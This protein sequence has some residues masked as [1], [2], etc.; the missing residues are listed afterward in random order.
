MAMV[1]MAPMVESPSPSGS[2]R[3]HSF[4]STTSALWTGPFTFHQ[5]DWLEPIFDSPS[6]R[7]VFRTG[8]Q[9]SKSTSQAATMLE[10]AATH[11]SFRTLYVTPTTQQMREFSN[12]RLAPMIKDSPIFRAVYWNTECQDQVSNRSLRNRSHITLGSAYHSADSLRGISSH[13]LCLDEVQD[14]LME[15]IKVL[16][17]TTFA[18]RSTMG[19]DPYFL[20]CGTPKTTS[21]SIEAYWDASTQNFW[22]VKCFHCNFWNVPLGEQNVQQAGLSCRKCG[23]L[24][25]DVIGQGEW[26]RSFE[27]K[28]WQ[29]WHISQLMCPWANWEDIWD[30]YAGP[31]PSHIALFYNEVAGISV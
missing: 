12:L 6:H 15:N 20:Y 7:V 17:Q 29:G 30:Q 1:A 9:V 27:D 21:H 28:R 14:I 13:F 19:M 31:R 10:M 26:I 8:R 3:G 22:G 4:R 18:A 16:E 25:E 23:R 24:I 2:L 11:P 5:R